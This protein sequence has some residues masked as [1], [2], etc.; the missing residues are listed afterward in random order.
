MSCLYFAAVALQPATPSIADVS[1]KP[2]SASH[3][4]AI[5]WKKHEPPH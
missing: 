1:R 4:I 3:V 2:G 5:C